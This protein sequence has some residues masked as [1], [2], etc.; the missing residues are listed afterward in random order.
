ME[1]NKS[2]VALVLLKSHFKKLFKLFEVDDVFESI[3]TFKTPDETYKCLYAYA[4]DW[5]DEN[6]NIKIIKNF[7]KDIRHSLIVINSNNND[8]I[9]DMK[10][11]DQYGCDEEFDNNLIYLDDGKDSN[12]NQVLEPTI[13]GLE[14]FCV[15]KKL[16]LGDIIFAEE[17]LAENKIDDPS[18]IVHIVG[19]ALFNDYWYPKEFR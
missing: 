14:Y 15:S 6:K 4:T 1:T 17:K 11:E 9:V 2:M 8:I 13:F 5:N 16:K 18:K 7:I 3:G 10:S 19:D 12:G